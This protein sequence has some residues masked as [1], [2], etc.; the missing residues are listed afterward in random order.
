MNGRC[1]TFRELF[2]DHLEDELDGNARRRLTRHLGACADCRAIHAEIAT[3]LVELPELDAPLPHELGRRM[4]ARVRLSRGPRPQLVAWRRAAAWA[5]VFVGAWWQLAGGAVTSFAAS[6]VVPTASAVVADL[7]ES[8][9]RRAASGEGVI[10]RVQRVSDGL[11]RASRGASRTLF[12]EGDLAASSVG[13]AG[14]AQP[15]ADERSPSLDAN[16]S[17][18]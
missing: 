5:L 11:T 13:P 4:A 2:S 9:A 12:G 10:G 8:A 14:G 6:E 16:A 1:E 7:R 3:L 17:K 15:S 18:E